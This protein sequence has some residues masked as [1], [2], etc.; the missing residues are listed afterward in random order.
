M[1]DNYN[2][3]TIFVDPPR[4]GLDDTTRDLIKE[5]KFLVENEILF[6]DVIN[7]II[8]PTSIIEWYA[9]KEILTKWEND[10]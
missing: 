1:L 9:I 2:F 6:Y 4:A 3:S 5:F 7:G 8:K 10:Y